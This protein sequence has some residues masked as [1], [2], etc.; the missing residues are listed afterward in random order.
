VEG[1]QL[2]YIRTNEIYDFIQ[3]QKLP[4]LVYIKGREPNEIARFNHTNIMLLSDE[5][6]FQDKVIFATVR[7]MPEELTQ[8]ENGYEDTLNPKILALW[9][10]GEEIASRRELDAAISANLAEWLAVQ[11]KKTE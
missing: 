5:V 10:Q 11:L 7:S 4:V 6:Q 8:A 1:K 2:N 9:W 3:K